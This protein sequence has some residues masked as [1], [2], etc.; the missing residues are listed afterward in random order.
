MRGHLAPGFLRPWWVWRAHSFH[1]LFLFKDQEQGRGM[2]LFQLE[3]PREGAHAESSASLAP[4][5]HPPRGRTTGLPFLRL[6]GCGQEGGVGRMV[7][8]RQ[9]RPRS[10]SLQ[11]AICW[12]G[13]YSEW[14]RDPRVK[15]QDVQSGDSC[16]NL[17]AG[18]L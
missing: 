13:A 15:P 8:G 6:W 17:G 14:T 3:N 9:I 16:V 11:K 1:S 18:Y 10:L 12:L 2:L 4:P 7:W 5:L